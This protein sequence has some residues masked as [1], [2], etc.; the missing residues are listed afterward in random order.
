MNTKLILD[1]VYDHE[2]SMASRVYMTQPVGQGQV[3]DYTWHETLRQARSMAA[4][5]Q[6]QNLK[7][8]DRVAILSKNCAHFIKHATLSLS[9]ICDSRLVA[10][11]PSN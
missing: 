11:L 2:K 3:I 1:H 7:P 4:Y 8:G 10:Y 9:Q 5:L 6:G